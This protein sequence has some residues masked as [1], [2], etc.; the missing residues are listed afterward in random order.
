L[1]Q[2]GKLRSPTGLAAALRRDRGRIAARRSRD[3]RSD[4][5]QGAAAIDVP[6][7]V[8]CNGK[9]Q[10]RQLRKLDE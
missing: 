1:P 10:L 2:A 6:S 7:P 9:P 4:R 3:R 8:I 5:R